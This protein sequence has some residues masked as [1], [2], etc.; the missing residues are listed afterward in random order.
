MPIAE[1]KDMRKKWTT[2][3]DGAKPK[4][5][6]GAVKGVKMGNTI[7]AVYKATS[8]DYKTLKAAIDALQAASDK[9]KK[10][11]RPKNPDLAKWIEDKLDKPAKTLEAEVDSDLDKLRH[12][13]SFYGTFNLKQEAHFPRELLALAV[14]VAKEGKA[15]EDIA[16]AEFLELV[17]A[18]MYYRGIGKML[19]K[20]ADELTLDLPTRDIRNKLRTAAKG[21]NHY[22]GTMDKVV[23]ASRGPEMAKLVRVEAAVPDMIWQRAAVGWTVVTKAIGR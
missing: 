1:W 18:T 15:L 12:T 16:N 6:M 7:D 2:A 11:I 19:V 5:G 10:A 22:A 17:E 9:Y 21:I 23:A 4:V 14:R 8:T 3:R 13:I 20:T